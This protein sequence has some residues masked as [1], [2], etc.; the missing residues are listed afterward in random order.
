MVKRRSSLKER[1][2]SVQRSERKGLHTQYDE[3]EH[4]CSFLANPK[5]LIRFEKEEFN[6]EFLIE[7]LS[8]IGIMR[9]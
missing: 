5:D 6:E 4:G 7:R 1:R 9:Q 3:Y 2:A 8:G